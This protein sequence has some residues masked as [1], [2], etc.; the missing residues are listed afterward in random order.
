MD[1]ICFQASAND[2]RSTCTFS[3]SSVLFPVMLYGFGGAWTLGWWCGG[4]GCCDH[5]CLEGFS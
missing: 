1:D 2:I 3:S 4:Y 5:G